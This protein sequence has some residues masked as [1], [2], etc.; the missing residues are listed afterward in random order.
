MSGNASIG[1]DAFAKIDGLAGRPLATVAP[2]GDGWVALASFLP[3]LSAP[4]KETSLTLEVLVDCSG[5]MNGSQEA[6]QCAN[7]QF[8]V[9]R[10][11]QPFAPRRAT[12]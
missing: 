11:T 6:S 9:H 3:E 1:R 7:L 12:T 8:R 10:I 4:A 2:D 5:S